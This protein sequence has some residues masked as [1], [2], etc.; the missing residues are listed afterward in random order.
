MLFLDFQ[1]PFVS[2]IQVA[3]KVRASQVNQIPSVKI[4]GVTGDNDLSVNQSDVF[5]HIFT[6]PVTIEKIRLVKSIFS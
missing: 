2:G 6:K 3:E 1:M 4:Y 5:D